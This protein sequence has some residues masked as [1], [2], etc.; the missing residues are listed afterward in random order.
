MQF[1]RDRSAAQVV[2]LGT[3][4]VVYAQRDPAFR[5]VVNHCALSLCDT[6]GL[7]AAARR[8]GVRL[9]ERVT[10]VELVE[11]L[12]ARAARDGISGIFFR[13]R[14]RRRRRCGRHL[15]NALCGLAR[16]GDA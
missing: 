10:G 16:G 8:R 4:M 7:L 1:V 6:V 15:G 11:H 3:E 5:D 14:G 13:R 2:T 9:R 12:C